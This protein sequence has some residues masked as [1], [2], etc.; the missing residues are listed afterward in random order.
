[1]LAAGFTRQTW[2]FRKSPYSTL[3]AVQLQYSTGREA[4]KF[5]YDGEFRRENSNLYWVVDA[6]ASGLENLNY[7][8]FGN[9]S[10]S[11]PPEGSGESFYDADSDTYELFLASWWAPTRTLEFYAGPEVKLTDTASSG[12]IGSDQPDGL[13][14]FGQVGVKGGFDLDT[15]GHPRTG[16]LGDQFRADGKPARSGVRLKAEGQYY[17]DAWDARSFGGVEGSLRGY[18]AGRRAMLAGR[19]GGRRVWG[20]YPWFEAAFVGGSK[21]L[22][23]Y[24]KNRFAGDA[25]LY[26][27]VEARLWLFKGRLIAPG[28]W[29][30]FGL[31]DTGR[32]SSRASRAAAGTRLTGEGCSSR[33]TLSTPCSTRRSRTATK[34]RASTWAT[35]LGSEVAGRRRQH[36]LL[37]DHVP[38][39]V[40]VRQLRARSAKR[41]LTSEPSL[42]SLEKARS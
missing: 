11:H 19:V 21:N 25:S 4:F 23:G 18:L 1:M 7:F 29:G 3:Q 10:A 12:F 41:L 6:Q 32:V 39:R 13:G 2:G 34:A 33:C 28:R 35:A 30:V 26:G 38:T 31:A 5:T 37:E 40:R 16:T 36:P 24:R 15:R 14:Q 20:D 22:R 42:Y 17:P 8:G 9:D 27:S